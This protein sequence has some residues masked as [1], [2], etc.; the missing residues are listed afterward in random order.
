MRLPS[1]SPNFLSSLGLGLRPDMVELYPGGR[2][3]AAFVERGLAAG[4][5]MCRGVFSNLVS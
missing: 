2:G 3:L 5:H 4:W 1:P